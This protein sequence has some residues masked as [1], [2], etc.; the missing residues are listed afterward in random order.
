MTQFKTVLTLAAVLT[1]GLA[2]CSN[3]ESAPEPENE[4]VA[5]TM[6]QTPDMSDTTAGD[7]AAPAT[8]A[9]ATADAAAEPAT[10]EK[11]PAY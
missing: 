9:P 8:S 10:P 4:V 3:P 7:V 6:P 5:E 2:A 1:A 11:A